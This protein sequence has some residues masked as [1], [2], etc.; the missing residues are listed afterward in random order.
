MSLAD[1]KAKQEQCLNDIYTS[2]ENQGADMPDKKNLVNVA[3]A[4]ESILVDEPTPPQIKNYTMVYF[5]GDECEDVTGGWTNNVTDAYS[6]SYYSCEKNATNL[7]LNALNYGG[8][9]ATKI[10]YSTANTLDPNEYQKMFVKWYATS[11]D[12]ETFSRAVFANANTWP[13]EPGHR[14]PFYKMYTGYSQ[15]HEEFAVVDKD[16]SVSVT[17]IYCGQISAQTNKANKTATVKLYALGLVKQDSYQTLLNLAGITTSY[18]NETGIC[19]DY[20]T[21]SSILN[22]E[23]TVKYMVYNCTGTFMLEFLQSDTSLEI[24]N[25]SPYKNL[26][27]KNE[28]WMKFLSMIA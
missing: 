22:N 11:T 14:T 12:P 24:L 6:E 16:T 15:S 8:N 9:I 17:E 10:A 4:I 25:S 19:A 18:S 2:L 28:V 3:P 23:E 21:M 5:Y 13:V 7:E 1:I 20:E 26:V 27:Y